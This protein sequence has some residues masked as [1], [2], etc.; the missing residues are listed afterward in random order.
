ML[1]NFF[2]MAKPYDVEQQCSDP[3]LVCT[4]AWMLQRNLVYST[5]SACTKILT[6]LITPAYSIPNCPIKQRRDDGADAPCANVS[7]L[8]NRDRLKR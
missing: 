2:D 3:E 7:M 6:T 4:L 5:A 1:M 8:L